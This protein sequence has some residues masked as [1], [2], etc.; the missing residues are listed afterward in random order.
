MRKSVSTFAAAAVFVVS[1]VQLSWAMPMAPT[2]IVQAAPPAAAAV[3]NVHDYYRYY[4]YYRP[5]SYYPAYDYYFR[6]Y[7]YYGYG[8]PYT[9]YN[10]YQTYGCYTSSDY[11]TYYW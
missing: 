2:G 5:Y 9:Y 11:C 6:P 4:G 8:R 7:D 3:T 10:Y 1:T